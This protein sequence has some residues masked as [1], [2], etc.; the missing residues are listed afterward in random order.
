VTL[1]HQHSPTDVVRLDLG[2]GSISALQCLNY[3]LVQNS[4]PYACTYLEAF[5]TPKLSP[6]YADPLFRAVGYNAILALY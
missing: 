5:I 3:R 1:S 2:R 4:A 6:N